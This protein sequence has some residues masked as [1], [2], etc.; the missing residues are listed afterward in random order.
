MKY[1]QALVL[2]LFASLLAALALNQPQAQAPTIK[3]ERTSAHPSRFLTQDT[4][5]WKPESPYDLSGAMPKDEDVS[6][7]I[8]EGLELVLSKQDANGGWDEEDIAFGPGK[9]GISATARQAADAVSM[10]ALCCMALRAHAGYDPERINPAIERG[11][12]FVMNQVFRG[13]LRLDVFYSC[14]RYSM[15]LQLLAEEY[16]RCKDETRKAEMQTCARRMVNSLMKLQLSNGEARLL[17]RMGKRNIAEGA[18]VYQLHGVLGLILDAPTDTDFRG[19]APVKDMWRDGPAHKGGVQIGD[20]IIEVEGLRIENAVDYY[21][22]EAEFLCGQRVALKV[23]RK[24]GS[25]AS[26]SCDIA[27]SWAAY[28]GM[29]VGGDKDGKPRVTTLFPLSPAQQAGVAVGDIVTE[30]GGVEIKTPQDYFNQLYKLKIGEV[31]T[32]TILRGEESLN[33]QLQAVLAPESDLGI[34]LS[35]EDYSSEAGVR[36]GDSMMRGQMGAAFEVPGPGGAALG[37]KPGDRLTHINN[38]PIL[39]PEQALA[40]AAAIPAGIQVAVRYTQNGNAKEGVLVTRARYSPGSLGVI[41]DV[42]GPMDPPKIKSVLQNGAAAN[43]GL[44]AGDIIVSIA[45]VKTPTQVFYTRVMAKFLAGEVVDVVVNRG[46]KLLMGKVALGKADRAFTDVEEGGWSYY[47]FVGESM[48]FVTSTTLMALYDAG[49]VLGVK[50]PVLAIKAAEAMVNGLRCLDI[51]DGVSE[52][53]AYRRGEIEGGAL[54]GAKRPGSNRY[55][56]DQRGCMG[57][58]SVCELAMVRAGKRSKADLEKTLQNWLKNRPELDKVRNFPG[59]HYQQL[60]NNAAYYW[61]FGHLYSLKAA[62]EVGGATFDKVNETVVKALMLKREKT[63]GWLHHAAFG[64]TCGTAMA[65]LALGESKG[66]WRK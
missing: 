4:S 13:R 37:M 61:L 16:P 38:I 46:G 58:N 3:G 14:W 62:R 10:T 63:G 60:Y 52:T 17:D 31:A 2:T 21:T 44:K 49:N 43:G 8:A 27:L 39:F 59:T 36:V 57:R 48:T 45:N 6:R 34:F 12:T 23:K 24:D 11:V 54:G 55:F 19:G 9:D 64:K 40:F 47:P 15:G 29:E 65:L 28:L 5:Q 32:I 50:A 20:R 1:L 66:G 22:A 25:T 30:L 33:G 42:S 18:S 26:V 41:L 51:N 53:Y 7:A 35:E 56:I